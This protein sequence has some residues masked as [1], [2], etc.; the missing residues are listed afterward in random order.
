MLHIKNL[1]TTL[2]GKMILKEITMLIEEGDIV[3]IV[4]NNGTGKSTLLKCLTALIPFEGDI[5]FYENNIKNNE[6]YKREIGFMIN[7]PMLY[8]NLTGEEH[9]K[10]CM[11]YK[12]RKSLEMPIPFDF[13]NNLKRKIKSYSS[14]MRQKLSIISSTACSPKLVILD[15]PHNSLDI[16]SL[17]QLKEYLV[18][19]NKRGSTIVLTS[20]MLNELKALCNKIIII[21]NG[22][23][24][25]QIE[26]DEINN[27]DVH[28]KGILI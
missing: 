26:G 19:I 6:D 9:L 17:H 1:S 24:V 16:L 28:V 18:E 10:I 3:G 14:G 20:H 5:V 22:T 23:I 7:A 11:A 12:G 4:G 13:E 2:D 25:R 15:E 27:L 21:Q 8:E